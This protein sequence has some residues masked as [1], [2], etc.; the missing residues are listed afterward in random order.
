MFSTAKV[1]KAVKLSNVSFRHLGSGWSLRI[2]GTNA[3]FASHRKKV[4]AVECED[5]HKKY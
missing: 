3:F 4:R 2:A 5:F 1:S